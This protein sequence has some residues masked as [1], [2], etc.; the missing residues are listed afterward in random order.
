[1]CV[2]AGVEGKDGSLT[3]GASY[4]QSDDWES[5]RKGEKYFVR[6]GKILMDAF[7]FGW[8]VGCINMMEGS[9]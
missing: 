2:H 8:G 5:L 9:L 7:T 1:M 3:N 4:A 6:V